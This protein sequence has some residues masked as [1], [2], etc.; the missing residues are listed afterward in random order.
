[1]ARNYVSDGHR[2]REVFGSNWRDVKDRTAGASTHIRE[3]STEPDC[4]HTEWQV[5]RGSHCMSSKVNRWIG[6]AG[7]Y[8]VEVLRVTD[9]MCKEVVGRRDLR[10]EGY[11][12]DLECARCCADAYCH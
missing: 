8:L 5:K 10:G 1:V 9:V 12:E 2:D 4:G 11:V 6:V 7:T 3:A